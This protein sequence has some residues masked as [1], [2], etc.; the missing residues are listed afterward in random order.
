MQGIL[1]FTRNIIRSQDKMI[2][3]LLLLK[4]TRSGL[5]KISKIVLI[6]DIRKGLRGVLTA[7]ENMPRTRMRY[8]NIE[9]YISSFLPGEV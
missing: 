9:I 2:H 3:L 1:K 5:M 7:F 8:P 4:I 6:E